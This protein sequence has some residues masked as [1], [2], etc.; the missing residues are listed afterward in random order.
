MLV[1]PAILGLIMVG[2]TMAAVM[3]IM[4]NHDANEKFFYDSIDR[5]NMISHNWPQNIDLEQMKVDLDKFNEKNKDKNISFYIYEGKVVLYPSSTSTSSTI[6][7]TALSQDGSHTFVM[8]NIAI[9]KEN[10]GEYSII[11]EDTNFTHH[12]KDDSRTYDNIV[13]N[14]GIIMILIIIVIILLTNR[15]LTRFVFKSIIIPLDT[16]VHGVRQI[17]DGNLNYHI[18]YTE[19][20]EFEGVCSD[21]NEMAQRLLD[22]VNARQKDEANRK[23]LIAGISHDLR[24]P[25]TSIKAYVEGLETGVAS[26]PEIQ[27]RY[28][29]TI[30]NKTID[31]EHIVSQLFLFS[32]LDI[33]EFPLYLE[34]VDIGKELS[35]MIVNL[36][37]EYE[38]KGLTITLT[39]NVK[40]NYVEADI[41]QL[42]NAV[43][44][45]LEN[46][47]KY[48]NREQGQMRVICGMDDN[49]VT[50]KLA[51]NG[52]GVSEEA[53][54][55]LFDIFY[56]TD[57]SRSNPSKGSGL[58]LSITAK[59]LEKL[60]GSIRAENVPEGGLAIVMMFPKYT[61]GRTID[62]C[63]GSQ[64]NTGGNSIEKNSN[65]RR[66]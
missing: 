9:H 57:P 42:R 15:F 13:F 26:T 35:N 21:F 45:I 62:N 54:E 59:I 18:K 5:I 51:D 2:G 34:K 33:G 14:L 31:L 27:K 47:V 25:L 4:G 12:S 41:V 11:I 50:I 3:E 16:L 61:G 23:E 65:Y 40:D 10:V 17:R 48:K 7:D 6:L 60:G 37:D 58:G 28:L 64:R 63:S 30:K 44:N 53:L 46:S 22:S 8:D 1:I 38:K 56:R 29:D 39:Q 24:T 32:K 66:R 49:Y 52:P 20:D 43:I 55:K 36:T 19:K